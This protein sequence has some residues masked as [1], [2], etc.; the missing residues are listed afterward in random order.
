MLNIKLS[1]ISEKVLRYLPIGGMIGIIFFIEVFFILNGDL[2]FLS[3][4]SFS[5]DQNFE[6]LLWFNKVES[7]PN[8][9]AIGLVIYTYY[10]YYFFLAGLILLVAM[11]GAISLTLL[12]DSLATRRIKPDKKK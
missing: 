12:K 8:I 10:I 6:Y 1:E 9:K 2:L 11:L 3:N 5:L 7:L 4:S